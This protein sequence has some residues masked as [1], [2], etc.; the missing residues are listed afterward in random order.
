MVDRKTKGLHEGKGP[1]QGNRNRQA[2]HHRRAPVLQKQK[3]DHE[4]QDNRQAQ[5]IGD[6]TNRRFNEL[7]NVVDLLNRHPRGNLSTELLHQ[8]HDGLAHLQ[9]VAFWGLIHPN[10]DRGVAMDIA[11][12]G[13]KRVEAIGGFTDI[14]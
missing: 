3:Q 11:S 2:G 8:V 4:H 14:L 5:G 10:G 1:H 7:A 13:R 9:G 12:F 6:A